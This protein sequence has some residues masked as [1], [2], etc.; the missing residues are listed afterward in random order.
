MKSSLNLILSLMSGLAVLTIDGCKN[1]VIYTDALMQDSCCFSST[2]RNQY[3]ILEPG[4]QLIL[5]GQE[6]G[7]V[8]QL[9]VTVL[10]ETRAIEKVETRIVEE[11]EFANGILKENSRNYFAFCQQNSGIYYFGEDVDNYKN[12]IITNHEGSWN[13]LGQNK[14]GLVMPGLV[15]LGARYYQEIAPGVAMDRAE[16]V[17]ISETQQTSAGNFKNC[18]MTLETTA[19]NPNEKEYKIYAPGIGL[20]KDENMILVKYGFIDLDKESG[21]R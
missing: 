5:E 14:A 10:N 6:R 16:I 17:S 21:T 9:Y 15:L 1:N 8:S 12:G 18:L 20:I 3:F 19:L 11:K 4:F 2:G 13:A 7:V